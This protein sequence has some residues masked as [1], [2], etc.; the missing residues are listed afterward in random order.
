[1]RLH[2]AGRLQLDAGATWE[3]QEV[4]RRLAAG[5]QIKGVPYGPITIAPYNLAH[6]DLGEDHAGSEDREGAE[7]A[8][9]FVKTPANRWYRVGLREGR[10]RELRKVFEHLEMPVSRIQRVSF[11]PL[12]LGT[13][14]RGDLREC[15]RRELTRLVAALDT[16]VEGV[17]ELT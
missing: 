9:G 14:A 4:V 11:G 5:M 3:A 8:E 1:M 13:L 17:L 10:N 2:S 15:S 12:Q 6:N 7:H 16:P